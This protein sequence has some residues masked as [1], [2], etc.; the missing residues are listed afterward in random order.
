MSKIYNDECRKSA[1]EQYLRS[2]ENS[3]F[4]LGIKQSQPT[5]PHYAIFDNEMR[6]ENLELGYATAYIG[7]SQCSLGKTFR[8]YVDENKKGLKNILKNIKLYLWFVLRPRRLISLLVNCGKEA[9]NLLKHMYHF[10][11]FPFEK[12]LREKGIWDEEAEKHKQEAKQALDEYL[13]KGGKI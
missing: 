5:V 1:W 6:K 10:G 4:G 12:E 3:Q 7:A 2:K 8:N 13:N 11:E 9:K